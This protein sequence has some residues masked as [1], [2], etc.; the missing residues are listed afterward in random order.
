M[1]NVD[2]AQATGFVLALCLL[3]FCRKLESPNSPGDPSFSVWRSVLSHNALCCFYHL[4]MYIFRVIG[5]YAIY[6]FPGRVAMF[7]AAA[8]KN[9]IK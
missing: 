4:H 5:E 9:K 3:E 8:R 7:V 6:K 1:S 2:D